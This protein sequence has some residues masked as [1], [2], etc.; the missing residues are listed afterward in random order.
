[1]ADGAAEGRVAIIVAGRCAPCHAEH[2]TQAG[3]GTA[4]NGLM[5]QTPEQLLTHAAAAE[6][7]L[8]AQAMPLGNLTGMTPEERTLLL[9][10]LQAHSRR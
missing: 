10:W 5:L 6:V 8:T 1:M 2:P 7:Q 9:G 4:P 3:F